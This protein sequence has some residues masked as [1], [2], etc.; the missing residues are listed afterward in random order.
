MVSIVF[1]VIFTLKNF[2]WQAWRVG[3]SWIL[4][5]H[6]SGPKYTFIM[7]LTDTTDLN[8]PVTRNFTFSYFAFAFIHRSQVIKDIKNINNFH[9]TRVDGLDSGRESFNRNHH[10]TP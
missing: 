7:S 3:I 4:V 9:K 5:P 6:Q 2:S 10:M 1:L 8:S